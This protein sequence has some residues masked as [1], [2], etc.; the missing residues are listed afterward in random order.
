[1]TWEELWKLLR[2]KPI[3]RNISHRVTKIMTQKRW[4]SYKRTNNTVP[5]CVSCST[6]ILIGEKIEPLQGRCIKYLCKGCIKKLNKKGLIVYQYPKRKLDRVGK[7]LEVKLVEGKSEV[8]PQEYPTIHSKG[9]V[10]HE[11]E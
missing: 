3:Q 10:Q 8:L 9:I 7:K 6:P 11:R 1:M 2:Q 4:T 5:R